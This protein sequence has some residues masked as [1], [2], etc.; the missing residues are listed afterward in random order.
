M[1]LV[2]N[3]DSGE[4]VEKITRPNFSRE[5]NNMN[6]YGEKLID[7]WETTDYS[8]RVIGVYFVNRTETVEV[9]NSKAPSNYFFE[10]LHWSPDGNYIAALDSEN[11]L[12]V[13]SRNKEFNPA[14][15]TF[16][17][18]NLKVLEDEE[19]RLLSLISWSD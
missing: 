14:I 3:I 10:S 17:E 12:I 5:S 1:G 11:N 13:F 9:F 16:S 18:L 6:V 19:R 8:S 15:V 2:V 4:V 7:P